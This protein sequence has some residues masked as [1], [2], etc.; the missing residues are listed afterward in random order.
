MTQQNAALVEESTA[1]AESLKEQAARLADVARSAWGFRRCAAPALSGRWKCSGP[2]REERLT[3]RSEADRAFRYRQYIPAARP[4]GSTSSWSFADRSMA[5]ETPGRLA[6]I[7]LWLHNDRGDKTIDR[8][9]RMATSNHLHL[10][11]D[12]FSTSRRLFSPVYGTFLRHLA[13]IRQWPSIH[14]RHA[15][16]KCARCTVAYRGPHVPRQLDAAERLRPALPRTSTPPRL[17]SASCL[18]PWAIGPSCR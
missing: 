9:L 15:G 11:E 12:R 17:R 8:A 10:W 4:G 6:P 7:M 13:G 3:K 2:L 1:A 5:L 16:R 14:A 18:L